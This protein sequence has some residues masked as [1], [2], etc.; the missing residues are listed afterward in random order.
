MKSRVRRLL[1]LLLCWPWQVLEPNL[2]RPATAELV[3]TGANTPLF[4]IPKI[5]EYVAQVGDK[6]GCLSKISYP[7][8]NHR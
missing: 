5:V 3:G 7:A 4:F 8:S 1:L 2:V 6:S